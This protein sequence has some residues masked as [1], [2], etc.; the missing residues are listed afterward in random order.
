MS[1]QQGKRE[2]ES[3]AVVRAQKQRENEGRS[4]QRIPTSISRVGGCVGVEGAGGMPVVDE[5][6]ASVCIYDVDVPLRIGYSAGRY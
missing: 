5:Y 4:H 6:G 3:S 2:R 1:P